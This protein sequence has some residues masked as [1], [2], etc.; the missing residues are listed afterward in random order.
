MLSQLCNRTFFSLLER[1]MILWSSPVHRRMP[2]IPTLTQEMLESS[3]ANSCDSPQML[4]LLLLRVLLS[5]KTYFAE[6][7]LMLWTY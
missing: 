2:N 4:L 7:V 5:P 3:P 6:T 1:E